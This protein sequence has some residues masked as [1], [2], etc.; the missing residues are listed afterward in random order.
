MEYYNFYFRK[1]LN[2]FKKLGGLKMIFTDVLKADAK[3]VEQL[4]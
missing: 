4:V 3:K 1:I 2:T